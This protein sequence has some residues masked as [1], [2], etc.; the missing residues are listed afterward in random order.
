ML[1]DFEIEELQPIRRGSVWRALIAVRYDFEL[2]GVE[3]G[4][5]TRITVR[6]HYD[7]EG[8][9]KGLLEAA[10]AEAEKCLATVQEKLKSGSLDSFLDREE[11]EQAK[12]DKPFELEWPKEGEA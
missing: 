3:Y 6:F 2:N 9:V 11:D 12:L 1:A 7:D 8:S 5:G 4:N 10:Y